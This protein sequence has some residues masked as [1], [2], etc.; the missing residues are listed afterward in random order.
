[1]LYQENDDLV[2]SSNSSG[3]KK[4]AKTLMH[5]IVDEMFEH[6]DFAETTQTYFK[7]NLM[8]NIHKK[9][10]RISWFKFF[11]ISFVITFVL[12]MLIISIY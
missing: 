11:V 2:E 8:K 6:T 12:A 10:T 3:W 4:M 1:M 5:A 9:T 7:H